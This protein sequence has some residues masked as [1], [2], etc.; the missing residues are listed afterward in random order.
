MMVTVVETTMMMIPMKSSSMT[1]TM[2]M[3]SPLQEGISPADFSL[4]KSFSLCVVFRLVEAK[5]YFLDGS[6]GL[7]VF[8]GEVRKGA[9]VVVGQGLHTTWRHS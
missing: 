3:I 9:P 5:E 6:S 4:P 2:A 8:G 1:M 7:R